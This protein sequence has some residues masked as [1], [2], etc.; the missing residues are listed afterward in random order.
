[1]FVYVSDRK[2]ES[3]LSRKRN[4][5]RKQNKST[6]ILVRNVAFEANTK[7]LKQLFGFVKIF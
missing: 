4:G 2:R 7:E 3:L 6:K 1:M 5:S